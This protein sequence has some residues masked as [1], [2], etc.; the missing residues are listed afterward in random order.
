MSSMLNTPVTQDES[1][2]QRYQ[3]YYDRLERMARERYNIAL[4]KEVTVCQVA[5]LYLDKE[6]DWAPATARLYRAALSFVFKKFGTAAGREACDMAYRKDEDAEQL[7]SLKEKM[8]SQRKERHR[9]QPQT[10][11]QKSKSL[12]LEDRSRLYGRLNKS[13]SK[14]ARA[15]ALWFAAGVLTGLRPTEWQRVLLTVD[16]QH[17]TVLTVKNAKTSNGRGHGPERTIEL[18]K[19]PESDIATVIEHIK[20]VQL[21]REKDLF[22][23][24]YYQCRRILR[25]TAKSLWPRRLK[26]PTLYTGRHI[27]AADAKVVHGPVAVAAMMGHSSTETAYSHYGKRHTGTG[28]MAAMP[29]A[30]DIKAV[31]QKNPDTK[32]SV[33]TPQ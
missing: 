17:Q 25:R 12:S 28:G 26:H 3:A 10:S 8:A 30:S 23:D 14:Y 11:A 5:A 16:D 32:A 9:N 31:I 18:G 24:A 13:R 2:K 15:T 4:G 20:N 7:A 33:I 22:N 27:F 21:W 1:T 19:F 29:N 6:A